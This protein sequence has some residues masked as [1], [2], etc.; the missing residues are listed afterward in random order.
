M[1]KKS[2]SVVGVS[3]GDLRY[4]TQDVINIISG[5]DYIYVMAG[6]NSWMYHFATENSNAKVIRYLPST[7]EWA[8]WHNDEV[9]DQVSD[10]IC[11]LSDDFNIVLLLAGDTTIYSNFSPLVSKFEQLNIPFSLQPGMSF[12]S[13]AMAEAKIV[14]PEGASML[15]TK[16]EHGS[17]LK[18]IKQYADVVTLYNPNKTELL[19]EHVLALKPKVAKCVVVGVNGKKTIVKDI[20]FESKIS[21]IVILVF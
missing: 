9:L 5:A 4:I 11:G 16:L 2:V 20:S 1:N 12:M 19:I 8:K 6:E 18:N 13:V 10:D 14:L 21:G 17:E 15:V 3:N 7:L